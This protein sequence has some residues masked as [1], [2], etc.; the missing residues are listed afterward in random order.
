MRVRASLLLL[1]S[2][3]VA[4]KSPEKHRKQADET[5]ARIIEA[6]QKEALG[7]TEPFT[8]ERPSDTLRR[9]LLESQ[10]LST[11]GDES[12]G[13]DRLARIDK[14]PED[15]PK[16]SDPAA[17]P[18]EGPQLHT[19]NLTGALEAGARNS[20]VYQT[21]KEDV[22]RTALDLDL[23][24]NNFRWIADGSVDA[25]ASADLSEG[26]ADGVTAG[27]D[28]GVSRLLKTGALV[29]G[30]IGIDLV[31]LLT[32]AGGSSLGLFG[33]AS[34]V[35]PLLRGAGRHVVLEPLTQAERNVV[36]ALQDFDRFRRTFA[37]Q[38]ADAYFDVLRLLDRAHN[39]EENYRNLVVLSRRTRALAASGRLPGVQVDQAR[40]DELRARDTWIGALQ[41]YE[42]RL[43]GLKQTLGL[44]TDARIEL[45]RDD[46]ATMAALVR[47]HFKEKE[48]KGS[49]GIETGEIPAADAT[50]EL[51]P[52]DRAGRGRYELDEAEALGLAFANRQDLKVVLGRIYDA[53]R[54]V[55]V[56]A[57]ALRAGLTLN[58]SA[59]LGEA[60]T[61]D[62]A[63][64]PDARFDPAAG[65]Y[66]ASLILD[67]PFER[68]AERNAYREAYL[69]L[70]EAVRD[71]QQLEDTIK[72]DVRTALRQLLESRESAGIQIEAVRLAADRVKSTNLFLEAGRAQ[73]RDVLE[74]QESLLD[75]Q[76]A[77]TEALV[78]YRV[79][80]L[81]F[82]RD[83]GV[84]QVDTNGTWTE[85]GDDGQE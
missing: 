78:S 18:W 7:H 6:K 47:T 43:D 21:R 58:A 76:N 35:V 82:Q 12:L 66:S 15:Y 59:S 57:D 17:P 81:E 53:Q 23:A 13:T 10:G 64:M 68:T 8:V 52:P 48:A 49:G 4:C 62:S 51:P 65:L 39:A 29:A 14:W 3:P 83:L 9:R 60:R 16:L 46:L 19:L 42:N 75:A 73:V 84:L 2:F 37:V 71:L 77:L 11:V 61:L 80:E 1:L 27:A 55:V 40:Q 5:A 20:R 56:K 54:Q 28:L 85:L 41:D 67:L 22:F 31:R 30:A 63:T 24:R 32:G 70:E 38:V 33:D 25:T 26:G 36:Y 45:D 72:S 69:D 74:A 44:P 79:A 50:V 34:I